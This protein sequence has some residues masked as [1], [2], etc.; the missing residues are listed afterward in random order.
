MSLQTYNANGPVAKCGFAQHN[1]VYAITASNAFYIWSTADDDQQLLVQGD[2]ASE[3]LSEAISS[4]HMETSLKSPAIVH[5]L[6]STHS[7]IVD[8]LTDNKISSL[9]P[10]ALSE[11]NSSWPLLM[12]DHMG[13]MN[14]TL[15]SSEQR[16]PTILP[17]HSPHSEPIRAAVT[18]PSALFSCSDDGQVVRW[19]QASDNQRQTSST[20]TKSNHRKP[21]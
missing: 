13:K 20:K 16:A 18:S 12:C 9:L 3:I 1:S 5:H 21:Y 2:T 15:V 14:I 19:Q 7:T 6:P 17:L 11:T 10:A 8:I 4:E